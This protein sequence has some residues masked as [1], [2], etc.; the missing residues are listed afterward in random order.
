MAFVVKDRVKVT[1]TTTGTGTFTLGA[2][3]GISFQD[4]SVIG[5]GN[6][7]SYTIVDPSTGAFEVGIGT[8]T[9]SGTTLSRD[10]V[11]ESSNAGSLVDFA[12][13]LKEVFVAYPAER[14][15]F[16]DVAQT[17]TN[18]TLNSPA[19]VT[20]ALGTPAS[21]NLANCTF[22]TLNQSTTGNA[23]TAT[24]LQ[25]ARTIN[26]TSFNGSADITITAA[27][28]NVATQLLSLGVGTAASATT[29]EIRATNNITAYY[30]DDRLKTKLGNI[31]N[32]LDKVRS[33]SGFYYEANETAQALGYEPVREVGVSAQQVQAV[34]PEVVA[35]A[36]I[37][38]RYL[39]VRYER[40]VPLLIEAIK[41]LDAKVKALEA[42]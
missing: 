20:P 9:A 10:E 26:G 6:T 32:A 25:T 4:F 14:A 29:G 5:D 18:K 19:L 3:A 21:G 37:D 36:P 11:L 2:A 35:P 8:Y 31:E 40:L 12:A 16:T 13:G 42:K 27:A 38:D 7:T 33:L 39:T 23:A 34:Q 22:P 24:I 17:L 15:V 1:S 28:T 41:E 30:S